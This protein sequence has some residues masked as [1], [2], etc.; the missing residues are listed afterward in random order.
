MMPARSTTFDNCSVQKA[1]RLLDYLLKLATQRTK[2]IRDIAEYEKVLW[3]SDVPHQPN[4]YTQAWGRDEEHDPDEWLEV[5]NRPEPEVPAV[6][7]QCK[8]WVNRESLRNKND[9]PQLFPEITRQI[10]N[11]DWRE[12]SDQPETIPHTERLEDHPDIQRAWERYLED[13]WLPWTE[14]HNAWEKVHKVYS[15]LFAIHQEQLRRGEEYELVLGLGLLTWQTPTGQRVRH[16]LLLADGDP[17]GDKEQRRAAPTVADLFEDFMERHAKIYLRRNSIRCYEVM[18]RKIIVPKIGNIKVAD[19]RRRDIEELHQSLK[20]T[21]YHANRTRALLSKMM[22]VAKRWEWRNDNP[23]EGIPKFPEEKRD[24]WL[25]TEEIERLCDA[26]DKHPNQSAANAIRLLLLTGA[27]RGEV[28]TATWKDFNL[29]LGVWTK[30]SHYTKQKRTEHVPLSPP[31]LQLVVSMKERSGESEYLF[32]GAIAGKPLQEIKQV[33]SAVCKQANLKS[34]RLH[35]LRHAYASHLVSSGMSLPI[36][37]RLLGHTQPQT[38][39]RYAHLADDPLRQ[40]TNRFASIV[41][42][43]RSRK[44]ADVVPLH[45]DRDA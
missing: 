12:G 30:P 27:R 44:R 23:C 2:L 10:Q 7:A 39:A 24:R 15:S 9:L 14:K 45:R 31:A 35:D 13:K 42:A 29:V 22:S 41:A 34:V 1:V 3:I 17:L 26:L 19:L 21:P 38:T 18:G 36:V 11:P 25:S 33:W 4:C 37:G 20:E 28:L 5:Q 40:A 32:P 6:P 43:A 8:D 16:H